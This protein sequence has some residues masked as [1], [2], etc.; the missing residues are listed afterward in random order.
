MRFAL[1][2]VEKMITIGFNLF[3]LFDIWMSDGFERLVWQNIRRDN[4]DI[5]AIGIGVNY[6][7][8]DTQNA[9]GRS[10]FT[11]PLFNPFAIDSESAWICHQ[12]ALKESSAGARALGDANVS[13]G[14]VLL[15]VRFVAAIYCLRALADAKSVRVADK[16]R[17]S[18]ESKVELANELLKAT[19]SDVRLLVRPAVPRSHRFFSFLNSRLSKARKH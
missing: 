4:T 7:I 5:V 9:I 17:R 13:L 16:A 12:I 11:G 19:K 10:V 1:P 6:A 3:Q 8:S 18:I 15:G 14:M 2:G